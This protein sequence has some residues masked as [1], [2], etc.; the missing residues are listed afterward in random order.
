M[1][2]EGPSHC[3]CGK[4][5]GVEHALSCPTGG[6]PIIRHNELRDITASLMTEVCHGVAVEPTLQTLSGEQMA[7]CSAIT[8]DDARVD[9]QA[10]GFWGDRKQRAFFDVKVFNLLPR[11]S[12]TSH[13]RNATRGV[14]GI[15]R[16]HS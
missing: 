14:N 4:P 16:T 9:I 2:A 5:F 6:F 7:L 11:A 10:T 15:R 8:T 13:W 3:I 1:G 12:E